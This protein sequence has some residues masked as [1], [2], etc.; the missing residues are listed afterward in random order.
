MNMCNISI[1]TKVMQH[2]YLTRDHGG[3]SMNTVATLNERFLAD[4][5]N[6]IK[7]SKGSRELYHV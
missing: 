5:E 2:L 7:N 4:G 1:K 3:F 6:K